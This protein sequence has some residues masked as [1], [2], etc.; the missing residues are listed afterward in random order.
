MTLTDDFT[1]SYPNLM[2]T[3]GWWPVLNTKQ[4]VERIAAAMSATHLT[5]IFVNEMP[6]IATGE[7]VTH[8]RVTVAL[9][10][11]QQAALEP[12]VVGVDRGHDV[13]ESIGITFLDD[14]P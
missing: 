7:P 6:L 13:H 9:T 8:R 10:D 4:V 2:M 12:R 3:A 14:T 11:E 1:K 5:V